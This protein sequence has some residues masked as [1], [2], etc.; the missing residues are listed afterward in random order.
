VVG[1]VNRALFETDAAA[2]LE[3]A[4]KEYVVTSPAN[5]GLCQT[6]VPCEDGIP[7]G[8]GVRSQ[9]KADRG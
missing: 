3:T 8:T 5:H 6:K 9:R 1:R 7:S 4:I 2:F